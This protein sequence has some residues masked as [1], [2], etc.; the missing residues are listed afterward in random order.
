[1]LLGLAWYQKLKPK[2]EIDCE[3]EDDPSFWQSTGFLGIVT[4]LVMLMLAFPY[5]S[6]AFFPTQNQKVV[7]VQES[8]IKTISLDINGMICSGCE[9]S[10]KHAAGSL[11]GVLEADASYDSGTAI[12]KFDQGKVQ[13]R[14]IEAAINKTGF[15]VAGTQ[16]GETSSASSTN[17]KH[18]CPLHGEGNCS[19]SCEARSSCTI[20]H[21]DQTLAH[22]ADEGVTVDVLKLNNTNDGLKKAFNEDIGHPR[23]VAVLSSVC[24]WCLDGAKQIRQSLLEQGGTDDFRVHIIWMDMLEDDNYASAQ[25]AAKLLNDPRVSH[26]YTSGKSLGQEIARKIAG[27]EGVAWDIYMF[28]DEKTQWKDDFPTPSD[29]IHQLNPAY[30]SWVEKEKYYSGEELKQ[31]LAKLAAKFRIQ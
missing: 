31:Q 7:Y 20:E 25:K 12:I 2:N 26:Y 11:D 15:T 19:G 23:F 14:D 10:V 22:A 5:Y 8:Q 24:R 28:Y 16:K 4:I 1:M 29:Y 18:F 30:Y 6:D 17:A 27:R 3:C 9:A 13:Q 21:L